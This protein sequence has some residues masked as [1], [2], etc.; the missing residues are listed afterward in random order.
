[1]IN[2]NHR[3]QAHFSTSFQFNSHLCLV[4]QCII[5]AK[6]KRKRNEILAEVSDCK[7]TTEARKEILQARKKIEYIATNNSYFGNLILFF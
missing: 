3:Q 4:L 6:K 7:L 5:V 1:M 2:V